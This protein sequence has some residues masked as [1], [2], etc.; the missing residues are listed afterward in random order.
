MKEASVRT[1]TL[2]DRNEST[3]RGSDTHNANKDQWS[4]NIPGKWLAN[5]IE[6]KFNI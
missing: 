5:I 6:D 1:P 4:F 2:T 3:L